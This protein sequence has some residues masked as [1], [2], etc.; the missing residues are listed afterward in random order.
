[1]DDGTLEQLISGYMKTSQPVYSFGWQGGEPT[2]MGADFFRKVTD[3]QMRFGRAGSRVSNG[4]QTNGTRITPELARHLAEYHVLTGISIDGPPEIHN[5][6]RRFPSGG[7]SYD[8]VIRGL[9]LLKGSG[10]EVNALVLVNSRNAG[11][12]VRIYR[13]LKKLGLYYHQYIPCVE[14]DESGSP[15]PWSIGGDEWGR[16]LI[17]LFRQ[18]AEKDL[19]TVSIRNF[20]A[21]LQKLVHGRT[22]MCTMGR[23]CGD[24]FVVEYN[25]DV[26]PCDFFVE[27]GL[28]LGNI[29]TH[30]WREMGESSKYREFGAKKCDWAR[31][32]RG[33]EFVSLCAG[34]CPKH[35]REDG[36]SVLCSGYRTFFS[37]T[38]ETFKKIANNIR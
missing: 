35:R 30:S 19:H 10:V 17:A 33:C 32:C 15:Q 28:K 27:P 1:M 8:D 16:F 37:T 31:E 3:L 4:L 9:E 20:D 6:G 21:V 12:A 2:L 23:N 18:W 38:L 26:Y 13:H 24:Y 5:E 7:G 36:L 22:A 29:H 34:D 14:F 11:H 25:G